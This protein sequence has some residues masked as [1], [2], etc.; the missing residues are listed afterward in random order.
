METDIIRIAQVLKNLINNAIKFTE[1]GK[2]EIGCMQGKSDSSIRFFVKDT[3]IGISEEHFEVI[4]D[5]FRQ[6]DGSN[7]RKFSGTGLGLSIC[8]GIVEAHGGKIWVESEPGKGAKFNFSL[9]T[10]GK[11]EL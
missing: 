11:G 8:R 9:Q 3:G 2:V 6:L 7:T 5:Q 4:F 10:D 1:E